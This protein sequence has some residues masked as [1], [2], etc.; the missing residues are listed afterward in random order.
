LPFLGGGVILIGIAGVA[1]WLWVNADDTVSRR[2]LETPRVSLP[3]VAEAA[4]AP[5][6]AAAAPEPKPAAADAAPA[7]AE[8]AIA[9]PARSETAAE[10]PRSEAAKPE[11]AK[12]EP[13][14]SEPAKMEP[15]KS[16]SRK[17]E[18]APPEPTR[19]AKS[20]PA[21]E[22]PK[23]ASAPPAKPAEAAAPAPPGQ[24]A[25]GQAAPSMQPVALRKAP[26]PA[27]TEQGPRGPVP[28]VA[29]DG[30]QAW[31][32]YGRPFDVGDRRPRIG[33]V[34]AELGLSSAATEAA[35]QNLPG[36]VT[37]AFEPYAQRL[38]EWMAT[39]RAAGHEALIMLPMEPGNFPSTD[40]GPYTLLTSLSSN[41]NLDRLDWV[42]S[43]TAGY[44]GVLNY[45]GTRFASS[46]EALQPVMA[47]LK[48]RGLLFLDG[49]ASARAVS[50]QLASALGVPH[51]QGDREIDL[52]ASRGAIDQRLAELEKLAREQGQAIGVG[53]SFP[54]TLERVGAWAASL[55]DRGFTLAPL[56]ALA[57]EKQGQDRQAQDKAAAEKPGQ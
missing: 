44:V 24:A 36:A 51:A 6:P 11:P 48:R 8:A 29:E 39:A 43:R 46:E 13:P 32:F 12:A 38:E 20:L 42:L 53:G 22:P 47:M 17:A 3:L 21:I 16:D 19:S 18:P 1:A 45:G 7:N 54:V 5:P 14:K 31:R 23:L 26:E 30:R 52:E 28:I 50:M 25:P 2:I 55:A 57:R 40:P 35:I 37:L 9:E 34:I 41:E 27:L 15:A 4:P 56:S 10:P 33:I 49:W